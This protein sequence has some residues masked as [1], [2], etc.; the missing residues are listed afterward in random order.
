M[1]LRAETGEDPRLAVIDRNILLVLVPGMSMQAADFHANGLVA[2]VEQRDWPVA[3]A[4]VDPGV[5]AYLDGSLEARL[6]DGI[7]EAR[8]SAGASRIWLA[9]ISLGCQAILRCVRARP[10]I[11]EG[12]MLLTPYLASTGLIAE[13][14]RAGGLRSW[15]AASTGRDEPD[16]AL[17]GWLAATPVSVLPEM[18]VGRAHGDRFA[19]TATMLADLLPADRVISVAGQ[20]DWG[21]WDLLWRRMLD[22]DPFGQHPAV[23]S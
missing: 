22:R 4:T 19:A 21:S 3:I 16:R 14:G 5:D 11:A 13:I 2:A 12:L 9:G 18:L 17:L 10:G 8:R 1:P 15:A 20:H 7:A 23:L 6:L